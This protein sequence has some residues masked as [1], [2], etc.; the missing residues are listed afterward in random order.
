[1]KDKIVGYAGRYAKSVLNLILAWYGETKG[2]NYDINKT[3]VV[4]G[5]PRTGTT[6]V[7]E[8]LT[9]IPGTA[10]LYEPLNPKF[11]S[12]I[13]KAGL[14]YRPHI[15][16]GDEFPEA[17]E[18][19]KSV[20]R[21]KIL[22]TWTISHSSFM[23]ILTAERW[24]VKFVR[25]NRLLRWMSEEFPIPPPILVIR[26]P[27][28]VIASQMSIK[29]WDDSTIG[30]KVTTWIMDYYTPLITPL[31]HPWILVPYERLVKEGEIQLRLIFDSLDME[32]PHNVY[33]RLCVPSKTVEESSAI[34][35]GKDQLSRWKEILTRDQVRQILDQVSEYGL[36]FYSEDLEPD[37]DR[38]NEYSGINIFNS[39]NQS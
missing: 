35:S 39:S 15:A 27:C 5:T 28:A 9:S 1:M 21:G 25:A 24:I 6:W 16:P 38:L 18:F 34:I 13:R 37:Y 11:V 2:K 31:P 32:V 22:N 23:Q 36:D 19:L 7:A 33:S 4:S 26:H 30:E 20:L 14:R 10:I 17:K 3:I 8:L 29:S 12:E